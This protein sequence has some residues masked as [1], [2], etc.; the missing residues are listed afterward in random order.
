MKE[1][2]VISLA[3][4]G[5]F[6][7]K[8]LD[9]QIEETHI[10]WVVLCKHVVFKIK[11]PIKL[12]FLDF[13]TLAKRKENCEREVRLNRRFTDIYQ[14]TVPIRLLDS[15]FMVGGHKG[16]LIDYAVQLKRLA[17]EK[18]MDN[19]LVKNRV[20]RDH[21]KALAR[22]ISEAH[23]RCVVIKTKFVLSEAMAL[24]NDIDRE[25]QVVE[26]YAG[27]T[28][29]RIITS[30]IQSSNA[31]L[32]RNEDRLQQ[33]IRQGFK[34]DVHGDLHSRNIFIYK[35]P[36]I[37]DC[38][39]FNESFRQIDVLY[40][41]AFLCMDLEKY[42]KKHLV[43]I[44]FTEYNKRFRCVELPEDLAIFNYFK[45]LRANVRAKVH[46]LGIRQAEN[47][48]ALKY[49]LKELKGYIRLMNRYTIS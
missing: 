13:S 28:Y 10:S 9:G 30:C 11:K 48:R 45:C 46:A 22:E 3:R 42:R 19:V 41:I 6:N 21:I 34:R 7:G 17:T 32:A 16:K 44:F 29:G 43:Q 31:F 38:I 37:F 25:I 35:K 2:E 26:D 15:K 23:A 39:E 27:E 1:D 40:E 8:P 18:R 47:D 14:G 36:V 4:T 24:F 12:S 33:R 20:R 49:H 5:T